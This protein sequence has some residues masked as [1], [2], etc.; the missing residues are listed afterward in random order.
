AAR[1]RQVVDPTGAG[2]AFRAGF[3]A[4]LLREQPLD[5]CGRLGS[6]AAVYAVEHRGT[7][8]HRYTREEFAE[9]YRENFG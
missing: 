1:V 8:E 5:V 3:L 2:D 4:G 7:Q 6:V 9:R